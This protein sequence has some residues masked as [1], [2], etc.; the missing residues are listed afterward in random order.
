MEKLTVIKIGGNIIDNQNLTKEFLQDFA[1]LEGKKILVHGGGKLATKLATSLQIPTEMVNGR[2]ITSPEMLDI[3]VMVYAGLINKQIV[4]QLQAFRCNA[5]G[6][7]GADSNL[8]LATQRAVGEVNYGLVGDITQINVQGYIDLVQKNIV[9]ICCAITHDGQGQLLNTNAD[10]IASAVAVGLSPFFEITLVY[11]FEK[12]GVLQ[13]IHNE[14]SYIPL[15]NK[16]LYQEYLSQKIITDGM[17]PKLDNAFQ[18]IDRGVKK[19]VI[20][21]PTVL[22]NWEGT[23]IS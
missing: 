17:L 19:V 5:L 1:A 20:G 6:V 2:R 8:L 7:S 9:P 16:D 15:I 11:C 12:K 23:V 3:A 4:A 22:Q 13:D 10:S 18:A 14:N 21:S